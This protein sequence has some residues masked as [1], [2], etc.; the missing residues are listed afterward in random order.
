MLNSAIVSKKLTGLSSSGKTICLRNCT[1]I[2][3]LAQDASIIK[4]YRILKKSRMILMIMAV[5]PDPRFVIYLKNTSQKA[6]WKWFRK[7]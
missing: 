5:T 7:R 1:A 2:P 3:E 6:E 4:E